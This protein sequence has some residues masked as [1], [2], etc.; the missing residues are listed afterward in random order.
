MKNRFAAVYLEYI[1][2]EFREILNTYIG[3]LYETGH[4]RDDGELIV[5]ATFQRL[6]GE[7]LDVFY[8]EES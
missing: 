6:L 1:H 3:G 8:E 2:S 4:E 5:S 7:E